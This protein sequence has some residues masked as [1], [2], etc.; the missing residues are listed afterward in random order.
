MKSLAVS[1]M[2]ILFLAIPFILKALL[3]RHI[4]QTVQFIRRM[5]KDSK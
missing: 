1:M 4:F 3:E 5:K 2:C